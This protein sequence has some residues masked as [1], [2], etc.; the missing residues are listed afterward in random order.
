MKQPNN[1]AETVLLNIKN[2]PGIRHRELVK[3]T[4]IPNSTIGYYIKKLERN[5]SISISRI[6]NSRRFFMPELSEIERLVIGM[7]RG[8]NTGKILLAL[9]K[10]E[11]TFSSL[12]EHLKTHPSTISINLKKL[13]SVGLIEKIGRD[14]FTIKNKE[15]IVET[16]FE[17]KSVTMFFVSLLFYSTFQSSTNFVLFD[18]GAGV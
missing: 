16:I 9:E 13:I 14:R 2:S 6:S 18:L 11:M 17:F 10:G 12:V 1:R 3:A 5:Q 7:L 15:N 8:K 4:G